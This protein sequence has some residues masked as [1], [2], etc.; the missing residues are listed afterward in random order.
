ML[1]LNIGMSETRGIATA[2]VLRDKINQANE[3][4]FPPSDDTRLNADT[5]VTNRETAFQRGQQFLTEFPRHKAISIWRS[6]ENLSKHSERKFYS[7]TDMIR[8]REHKGDLS[9][10]EINS[11]FNPITGSITLPDSLDLANSPLA[12]FFKD[13]SNNLTLRRVYRTGGHTELRGRNYFISKDKKKPASEKFEVIQQDLLDGINLLSQIK[14]EEINNP[15]DF[16]L[17][18]GI[19][20]Y[21]KMH[22]Q[23]LFHAL[24]YNERYGMIIEDSEELKIY[25]SRKQ[26]AIGIMKHYTRMYYQTLFG[27]DYDQ[28]INLPKTTETL[29]ELINY[30]YTEGEHAASKGLGKSFLRF[31]YPEINHPLIIALGAQEATLKY[32][33][34]ESLIGIPTGGTETA[35]VTQLIYERLFGYSP[36]LLFIPLSIHSG[37]KINQTPHSLAQID[38]YYNRLSRLIYKYYYKE[39]ARKR[40]LIIDD[41]SASGQTLNVMLRVLTDNLAQV[42]VHLAEYDG[43]NLLLWAKAKVA[44]DSFFNPVV[45]PTTMGLTQVGLDTRNAY[46]DEVKKRLES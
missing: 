36:G 41:N 30:A 1:I 26:Q 3:G 42:A 20:D 9:V 35:I 15:R 31:K 14:R 11:L 29:K 13:D 27:M 19:I 4:I 24:T 25:Q 7:L 6:L 28:Q 40:L 21:V 17:Y 37:I 39:V 38:E 22:S 18:L 16:L 45:S 34:S 2:P 43:R 32:P 8:F 44:P 10:R 46:L 12:V 23:T 5:L 33:E